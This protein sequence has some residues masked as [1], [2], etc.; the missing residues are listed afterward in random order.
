MDL[1]QKEFFV[2]KYQNA[3][4]KPKQ[5]NITDDI[6][7]PPIPTKTLSIMAEE[8][9]ITA[10]P[11]PI[12][13]NIFEKASTLYHS[14]NDIVPLPGMTSASNVLAKYFV[15]ST[16]DVNK[17]HL[18]TVL[19]T[20]QATCDHV[21]PRWEM[22]KVCAHV[23]AAAEESRILRKFVEWLKC[24]TNHP[25]LSGVANLNMPRGRGKKPNKAT[26]QRKGPANKTK[27]PALSYVSEDLPPI[28][29]P[30]PPDGG[31]IL[32][33]LKDCD[34]KVSKCYGCKGNFR[35]EGHLPAP[36]GDLVVVSR[37]RR[38]Y[39]KEGVKHF[40]ELSNVYFHLSEKCIKS[41]NNYFVPSLVFVAPYVAEQLKQAHKDLL[42]QCDIPYI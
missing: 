40:G 9:G 12:L 2:K 26:Q 17:P 7:N 20:G 27:R 37:A 14:K 42:D 38:E 10:V 16:T 19:Y 23:I 22:Y 15:T 21:C 18:V 1:K 41:H 4:L 31:Y 35:F 33:F 25:N 34:S 24:K 3:V 36:P 11:F 30:K 8:S 13:K 39:M 28:P 5:Q 6:E 29:L 32:Y